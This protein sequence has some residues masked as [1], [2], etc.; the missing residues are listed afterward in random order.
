METTIAQEKI[1]IIDDTLSAIDLLTTT[2]EAQGYQLFV[3]TNGEKAIKV[4][5]LNTPD[6]ILLDIVMPGIDGFET[7][8]RLKADEKTKTIPVIFMTGLSE[9]EDLVVVRG[10]LLLFDQHLLHQDLRPN[11]GIRELIGLLPEIR[12]QF[13]LQ[14]RRGLGVGE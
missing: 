12:A 4:A 5:T 11:A 14:A 9:T 3:A 7:C 8:R 13:G 10:H 2:L 1:L 6:L